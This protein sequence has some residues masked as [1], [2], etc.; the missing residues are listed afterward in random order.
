MTAL[1]LPLVCVCVWVRACVRASV[2]FPQPNVLFTPIANSLFFLLSGA[3]Y[4]ILVTG[5]SHL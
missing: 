5:S 4:S 1:D 3:I 2:R